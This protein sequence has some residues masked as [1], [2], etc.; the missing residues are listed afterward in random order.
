M[1][2]PEYLWHSCTS[3]DC[4][5]YTS[6]HRQQKSDNLVEQL[7]PSADTVFQAEAS[8]AALAAAES[9]QKAAQS[10]DAGCHIPTDPPGLKPSHCSWVA[11]LFLQ[12]VTALP[13]Q[14]CRHNPRCFHTLSDLPKRFTLNTLARKV[15]KT[16]W[17]WFNWSR[18]GS[19]CMCYYTP[20]S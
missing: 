3:R 2:Q 17:I 5:K 11:S 8:H 15:S 14:T 13:S 1:P 6:S 4:S 18:L 16:L 10:P 19:T 12:D 9:S 7:P 20:C